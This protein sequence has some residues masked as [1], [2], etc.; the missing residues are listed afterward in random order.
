MVQIYIFF[1][2]LKYIENIHREKNSI[3]SCVYEGMRK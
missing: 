3:Y 2:T 1:I